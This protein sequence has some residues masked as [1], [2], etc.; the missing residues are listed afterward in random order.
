[1][2]YAAFAK[3]DPRLLKQE[4]GADK[5][6][7]ITAAGE[8]VGDALQG[9][10]DMKKAIEDKEKAD[11]DRAWE[12]WKREKEMQD[13]YDVWAKEKAANIQGVSEDPPSF[14]GYSINAQGRLIKDE[15]TAIADAISP[16]RAERRK[17]RNKRRIEKGK[18]V[19]S[20]KEG[21]IELDPVTGEEIVQAPVVEEQESP[22]EQPNPI[23]TGLN[24][25]TNSNAYGGQ[26]K[27]LDESEAATAMLKKGNGALPG[28]ANAVNNVTE[29]PGYDGKGNVELSS[30]STALSTDP[31]GV[32]VVYN[33]DLGVAEFVWQDNDKKWHTLPTSAYNTQTGELNVKQANGGKEIQ[34]AVTS[35][36]VID[37]I[38]PRTSNLYGALTK[39]EFL[40]NK[41]EILQTIQS[42]A[43]QFFTDTPGA[44]DSF[45]RNIPIDPATKKPFEDPT[46]DSPWTV[47]DAASVMQGIVV[48]DPRF[49]STF[50]AVEK[51][52]PITGF[53]ATQAGQDFDSDINRNFNVDYFS[54]T[55]GLKGVTENEDG[56]ITFY[57][58]D[59][60]AVNGGTREVKRKVTVS[61]DAK[62]RNT[63]A[64]YAAGNVF[65]GK[66]L[67]G[68][69]THNAEVGASIQAR[70][71]R[72][73]NTVDDIAGVRSADGITVRD[74]I[75]YDAKGG[76][77]GEV[78]IV[79]GRIINTKT[80]VDL[81]AAP[82]QISLNQILV[83]YDVESI[84][85]LPSGIQTPYVQREVTAGKLG[86]ASILELYGATASKDL[87]REIQRIYYN[88]NTKA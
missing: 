73:N 27:D 8:A 71:T 30:L 11:E 79:D 9:L 19:L 26:Y 17:R 75:A 74:G 87:P 21:D 22:E 13:V 32:S 28:L 76:E 50:S 18:G 58:E 10:G 83:R 49:S 4:F 29:A 3:I 46:P 35:E 42:D 48:N 60:E 54:G 7:L 34:N 63:V 1:M 65:T 25:Q 61:N 78:K 67:T 51:K 82:E 40:G 15:A 23:H 20:Q 31:P 84:T 36:F 86:K 45:Q 2:A 6:A 56:T 85:D 81:G 37:K 80:N 44:L 72:D 62:G 57:V 68:I 12:T 55:L 59:I 70:E 53:N 33:H 64:Q 69:K 39:G 43:V 47:E 5:S 16:E 24:E 88:K 66:E 77:L 52:K 14:P 41:E 38:I